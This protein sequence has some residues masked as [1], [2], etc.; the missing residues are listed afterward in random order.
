MDHG[1]KDLQE[2]EDED[3]LIRFYKIKKK[4]FNLELEEKKGFKVRSCN[5]LPSLKKKID[6]KV[7][8]RR[9]KIH[10]CHK[11]GWCAKCKR[12]WNLRLLKE[13]KKMQEGVE[14]E[15]IKGKEEKQ[16]QEMTSKLNKKKKASSLE[17]E[18]ICFELKRCRFNP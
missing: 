17:V 14:F 9:K 13:K 2:K 16:E 7:G 4:A 15:I 8:C 10:K 11:H 6:S 18:E 3:A 1:L 12:E 5:V